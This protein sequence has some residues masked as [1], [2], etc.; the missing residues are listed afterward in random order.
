MND[1]LFLL[2]FSAIPLMTALS[3]AALTPALGATLHLRGEI[4]LGIV[5]PP[6]GSAV[7]GLCALCG[8]SIE[9]RLLLYSIVAASLFTLLSAPVFSIARTVAL[10][11]KKEMVLAAVF[12]LGQTITYLCMHLSPNVRIDLSHLLNGE[13]LALGPM[14]F[15]TALAMNALLMSIFY[16]YRGVLFAFC[17]DETGLRIQARG[18]RWI[19]TTYRISASVV[20]TASIVHVGPLLTTAWL[21][22][23]ALF[24]EWAAWSIE[25]F[26]MIG[27]SIGICATLIGFIGALII[28]FPPVHIISACIFILGLGLALIAKVY[29]K[30][31]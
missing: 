5:L 4:M 10:S 12:V 21:V 22:L 11:R 14:E 9:N 29:V 13:I 6:F 30:G 25:H 31:F 28:D 17:L 7:I 1:F 18:F 8:V 16:R 3:Y 19:E 27:L 2:G 24:A 20:I 26:F 23:P 15:G